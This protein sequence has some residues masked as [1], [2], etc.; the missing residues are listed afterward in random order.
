M[1]RPSLDHLQGVF[2]VNLAHVK[3]G[4]IIKWI[5]IL[6]HKMCRCYKFCCRR[7]GRAGSL[8]VKLVV[9]QILHLFLSGEQQAS[10]MVGSMIL[11]YAYPKRPTNVVLKDHRLLHSLT[12]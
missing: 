11:K 8:D 5:T 3:H 1:F 9:L 6:V 2:N 10:L 4:Q 12:C 7:I